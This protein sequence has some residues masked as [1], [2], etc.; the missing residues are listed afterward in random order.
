LKHNPVQ[1]LSQTRAWYHVGR[2]Q[3]IIKGHDLPAW[4]EVVSQ[5][6]NDV[7]RDYLLFLLFT[8][9]RKSEGLGLEI[10]QVD[11]KSRAYTIL[12]TKNRHPLT[13]PL[14]NHL[15]GILEK[16]ISQLEGHKYVFPGADK[17][18]TLTNQ[19]THLMEPKRHVTDIIEKS[20]VQFSLHDLRRHFI[21]VAEG[22]DLSGFS[23]KLLVNHSTGQDVTGGYVMPDVE[24]LRGPMQRVEDKILSLAG[25][26]EQ[27]KIVELKTA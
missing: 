17:A 2:R 3:T 23:I 10:E 4:Y 27:G 11:L 14:P 20:K 24:R 21:T 13:L 8:G 16:R 19:K 1:R 6:D 9:S 7:I 25:A 26:K 15:F 5:W 22:L 12:D 18:G